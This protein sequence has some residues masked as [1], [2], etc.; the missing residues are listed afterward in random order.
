MSKNNYLKDELLALQTYLDRNSNNL[1]N[2]RII[3]KLNFKN[4]T[5]LPDTYYDIV[6]KQIQ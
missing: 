6:N 5:A 4:S 2:T 3:L 1:F